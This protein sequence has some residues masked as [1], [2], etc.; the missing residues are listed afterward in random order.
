MFDGVRRVVRRQFL[1]FRSGAVRLRELLEL[2][3]RDLSGL[4][5][6]RGGARQQDGQTDGRESLLHHTPP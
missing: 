2:L 3:I 6:Q 4:R 1:V 5:K